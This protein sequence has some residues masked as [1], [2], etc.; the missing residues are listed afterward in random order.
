VDNA[1][2]A[3]GDVDALQATCDRLTAA[4]LQRRSN[5]WMRRLA[6]VFG[7][8]EHDALRPGYRYS[9]AQVEPAPDV[10]FKRSSPLKAMA[11]RA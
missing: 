2:L 3:V 11:R 4:L 10:I 7:P 5:Y 9:L 1:F 6:P 8:A